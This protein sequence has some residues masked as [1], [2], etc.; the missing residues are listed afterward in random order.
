MK[1]FIFIIKKKNILKKKFK[2]KSLNIV[3]KKIK[4]IKG[5]PS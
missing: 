3:V 2:T 1:V 4:V 5:A